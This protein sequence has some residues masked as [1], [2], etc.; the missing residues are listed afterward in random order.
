MIVNRLRVDEPVQLQPPTNSL[1]DPS[2]ATKPIK[3]LQVSAEP[4]ANLGGL[5]LLVMRLVRGLP[6]SYQVDLA[7]PD[8]KRD[9][10]P[11]ELRDRIGELFVTPEGHWS[12]AT[13]RE[14]VW[15]V[16]SRNYDLIHF[17]GVIAS[18]D[19]Y[20]PWRSPLHALAKSGMPW[21]YTNHCVPSF[22]AGLYCDDYPLPGKMFKAALAYCSVGYLMSLCPRPVFVSRENQDRVAK[23]FPWT[24]RKFMTIYP[25]GLEGEPPE[26]QVRAP[27]ITIGNLGHIAW[28]KGQFEL[29]EAFSLLLP[30]FP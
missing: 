11:H 18:F 16:R 13:K 23:Y 8:A 17:H 1:K 7:C 26:A 22:T 28:R 20:L 24:K 6:L 12:A 30:K 14:F 19:A 21:I 10:L 2:T 3:L 4:I 25:S 27:A 9:N 29:L 15:N 5:G